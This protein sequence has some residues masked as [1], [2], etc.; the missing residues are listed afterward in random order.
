MNEKILVL[1]CGS[2]TIKF[3]IYDFATLKEIAG[4]MVDRIGSDHA[5]MKIRHDGK[6]DVSVQNLPSH[7]MALKILL[8]D[9]IIEHGIV[10]DPKQFVAVG[11]R[12]A[13]GGEKHH[14]P[15]VI[16]EA[17]I[18]DLVDCVSL[19]PL[20]IPAHLA[21]I[22][23]VKKTFPEIFQSACFDT[24]FHHQMP[25]YAYLYAIP[26]SEY[27][28]HSIR[29]YGFH[30]ISHG[31]VCKKTVSI[32]GL[33]KPYRII[34]CHLGNGSSICAI[35]DGKSID[36]SMGFTPLEGLVMGTR[37]GDLDPA[38]VIY[39]ITR[40]GMTPQEVDNLLNKSSGLAG[41]SRV[42]N[43]FREIIKGMETGDK[44]C[45]LA[46]SLFCYR[47]KKY[48]SAYIGALGGVDA[49]VFTAGIGENAPLVREK[50]LEGLECFNFR[51][52]SVK[53]FDKAP[54]DR[55]ISSPGSVPVL[56]LHT[57]EEFE[58]ASATR[59]EYLKHKAQ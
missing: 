39:L 24:G 40:C 33:K 8:E 53:N 58:I 55:V 5:L 13:H 56:C 37:C 59:R 14:S 54:A 1:N 22:R 2:S 32:L 34:T 36:T 49:L 23:A 9:E 20:H 15:V 3:E 31:Y 27:K 57:D 25:D 21:G 12:V 52:D 28:R 7:E 43:D 41:L 47:L 26:I 35:K 11:H 29:R 16:T 42:G 46:F 6:E 38:V 51:L 45:L 50:T 48:I 4:G 18:N 30:G 44:N 17:V 10:G 19:A